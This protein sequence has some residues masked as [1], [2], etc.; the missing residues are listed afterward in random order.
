M[1]KV[2]Q[3]YIDYS[4]QKDLHFFLGTT[5]E[6]HEWPRTLAHHRGVSRAARNSTPAFLTRHDYGHQTART[7]KRRGSRLS[8]ST[9]RAS[10][11]AVLKAGSGGTG[12]TFCY[13]VLLMIFQLL[14]QSF[15]G[16]RRGG[17]QFLREEGK[18]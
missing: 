14:V 8:T 7:I 3:K 15:G 13:S 11:Q 16:D 12:Q 4:V 6:Y 10:R 9:F 5:K 18:F 2:R 17:A 1:A